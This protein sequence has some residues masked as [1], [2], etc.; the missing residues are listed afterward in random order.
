M[1][2]K[3]NDK[4]V[5]HLMGILMI[6][7]AVLIFYA[8]ER[9]KIYIRQVICL[10]GA[11]AYVSPDTASVGF[12][13]WV[14]KNYKTSSELFLKGQKAIDRAG[15]AVTGAFYL[16]HE[17]ILW[18]LLLIVP[19][20]LSVTAILL[21]IR[22]ISEYKADISGKNDLIRQLQRENKSLTESIQ[23]TKILTDQYTG[24]IYHQV[25]NLTGSIRLSIQEFG[26]KKDSSYLRQADLEIEHLSRLMK[27]LL[28]DQKVACGKARFSFVP[29]SIEDLL[30]DVIEEILPRSKKRH[31]HPSCV[32]R[33][34]LNIAADEYW[35]YEA[36]LTICDNALK[37]MPE[38]AVLHLSAEQQNNIVVIRIFSSGTHLSEE[39]ENHLFER[40]YSSR[41]GHFG[42]GLHMA[43]RIAEFH[44][45][46][47]TAC[48]D[49]INHTEGVTFLMRIPILQGTDAYT[50]KR[51]TD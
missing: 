46:S 24:N 51:C 17:H 6:Q 35:L 18:L 25:A 12:S 29:I 3:K 32:C 27:L 22:R 20:F 37:L 44:H 13:N 2:A 45:G 47:L 21:M 9:E 33:R 43:C 31:L 23:Q 30:Q 10:L 8:V 41:N 39:A 50:D 38:G 28:L 11:V 36:V 26:E 7:T 49:T 15:Y 19:L 5:H 14:A 4:I 34:P 40:F 1:Q 42:I 16:H 48:N